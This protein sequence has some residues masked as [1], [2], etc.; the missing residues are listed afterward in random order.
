MVIRCVT[1][2]WYTNVHADGSVLQ[3]F[4]YLKE[5]GLQGLIDIWPRPTAIAGKIIICYALFEA[6]LQLLLPGKRVEGPISPTG[7]RPVYK[8]LDNNSSEDF[9]CGLFYNVNSWIANVTAASLLHHYLFSWHG[10]GLF[11][12]YFTVNTLQHSKC[13]ALLI[14]GK[15]HG[16]IYIDTNYLS[17][18]LVVRSSIHIL[19]T[20]LLALEFWN[21]DSI[22]CC[23]GKW[24][25]FSL[26]I[27]A[28][29]GKVLWLPLW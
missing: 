25:W 29:H 15:W 20:F 4:N 22:E 11:C 7:H 26:G 14:A 10:K 28:L 21:F 3:T 8:V 6:S 13:Y 16:C 5:N 1:C 19:S 24:Y 12:N 2:R 9:P 17:Q 27:A 23:F 18:S